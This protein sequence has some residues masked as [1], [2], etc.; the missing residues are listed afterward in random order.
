MRV[1]DSKDPQDR[2]VVEESPSILEFLDSESK[3]FFNKLIKGL[4][5]LK[6]SYELNRFFS[7]GFRLLQSYSI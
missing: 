7:K 5:D 1:L 3:D 6:I 4:D 2:V